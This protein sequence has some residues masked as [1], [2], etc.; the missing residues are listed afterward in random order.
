MDQRE[1][2][3]LSLLAEVACDYYERGLTQN[4]IADKLFLMKD[5]RGQ[6]FTVNGI[7]EE[8]IKAVYGI[9]VD[10]AKIGERRFVMIKD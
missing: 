2:K 5:G 3:K 7:D 8:T 1:L 6:I 9:D 10:I 4:E